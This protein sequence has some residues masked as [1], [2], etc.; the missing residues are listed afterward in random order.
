MRFNF[1][2]SCLYYTILYYKVINLDSITNE[3]NKE[4]YEK[5][6][7]IP[8]HPYRILIIGGSGSGNTNALLN[9][10]KVQ[11]DIDKINLYA[12][13]LSEPKFEFLIKKREVLEQTILMIQMHLLRVQIEWM[14]FIRILMITIHAEKK[15]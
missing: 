10:L 5:L 14:T 11:D 15:I 6:L 12:K 9:L 8:D 7:F 3:N 4:Q 13:G 2:Q 1:L